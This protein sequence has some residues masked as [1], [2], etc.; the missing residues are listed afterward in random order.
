MTSSA[1]DRALRREVRTLA[2]ISVPLVT[3]YLAEMGMMITDMI[4]VGRLGSYELAAVGLTADWF[5]VLLLIGMGTVS[6]VGVLAAQSLGAGQRQG[7]IDAVEQGLIAAT[8][9]G[10]PVMLAVW[11]LG[12][13]LTLAR[14]DPEIVRL[15][16]DYSHPLTLGV[17]PVLWFTVLRNYVT[18]LA[19]ASVIMLIAVG[20]LVLNLALNYTLVYGKFGMPALGVVGA[21]I[22]TTIVNWTM[23]GILAA[24]V[25]LSRPYASYR[26][27]LLPAAIRAPVLRDI[28]VL[29]LPVT[30]AQLLGGGMFTVAAVL[31]GMLGA[32]LLAAQQIVYTVIYIALSASLAIGD[33][34]RVRVAYGIGARSAVAARRSATIGLCMA[35]A[36]TALASLALW[37][38]PEL[39]VSIF[40]DT[41]D[42]AN[43]SVL[44]LAVGLSVYAGL[45]QLFDGV[46]IVTANALRGLR[47]TRS[48]MWIGLSGY[49]LVGIGIGSIL[50]FAFGYGAAG[51]WW[52]LVLGPIVANA[53][54]AARFRR[55]L[56]EA[57][58][59]F[60]RTEPSGVARMDTPAE[61]QSLRR[62]SA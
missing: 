4:I 7:V 47:D 18:A 1:D 6:I 33:A 41:G 62:D 32:D 5:Y 37:L 13:A 8:I 61:A 53:L 30:G 59:R 29:G 38:A 9:M 2:G 42:V 23:F 36:V 54:M 12:P 20:A 19:R 58:R 34:V 44:L 16:T 55:R 24:R 3:A 28:F 14:Q 49:W 21:G 52:G 10:V 57:A 60:A 56:G 40:L 45:F 22:G 39:I 25:L 17:L 46:L 35:G 27:R 48:P 50:C 15:I 26:F 11:Y 31:V 43:T 51:L